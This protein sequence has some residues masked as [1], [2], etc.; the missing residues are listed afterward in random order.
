[1]LHSS[2]VSIISSHELK[3]STREFITLSHDFK[4]SL[5]ISRI[6]LI[7]FS[8]KLCLHNSIGLFQFIL[9]I[10]VVLLLQH[11]IISPIFCDKSI[12]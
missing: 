1:M 10:Y 9:H 4:I 2:H 3:N 8:S 11:K 7:L 5:H 12:F 6:H